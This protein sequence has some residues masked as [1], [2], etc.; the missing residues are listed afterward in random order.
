MRCRCIERLLGIKT[1]TPTG[2]A[3]C[4][5]PDT[6]AKVYLADHVSSHK[7]RRTMTYED[8]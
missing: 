7:G 1:A 3:S 8:L 4:R 5:G 6:F 2:A